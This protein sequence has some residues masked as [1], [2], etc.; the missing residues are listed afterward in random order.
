M[1]N[2]PQLD[3]I[4]FELGFLKVH[5]YGVMYVLGFVGAWVLASY[6]IEKT[7]KSPNQNDFTS[8]FTSKNFSDFMFYCAVGVVLGGRLGYMLFYYIWYDF[9]GFLQQPWVIFKLWEGGMSFHGGLLGVII[10]VLLF[11]KKY[12]MK[13]LD[14]ADF[15][16]PLVPIGLFFGRIGNFINDELWGRVTDVFW[17]I[18]FPSGGFLPRHPS[19]I[20]EAFLEGIVLFVI[21][22]LYSQKPRQKGKISAV[23]LIGYGLA[24]CICEFFREPDL[25]LGFIAYNW[26]TMGQLLS[27][28]MIIAGVV[29]YW[30]TRKIHQLQN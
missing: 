5:W 8:N 7:Q 1:L 9:H 10:G 12:H 13:F 14:I 26:L 20:Y 23:F 17:G 22:W 16:V 6:R 21:L 2:Y 3:P 19:Q 4:A 11:A 18:K 15:T 24:R 25:P 30:K 28:P 29:L 27:I